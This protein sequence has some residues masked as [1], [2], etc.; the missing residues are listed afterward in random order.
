[1]L[2]GKALG[3]QQA[4]GEERRQDEDL[5][6]STQA[7]HNNFNSIQQDVVADMLVRRAFFF[8]SLGAL[9]ALSGCSGSKPEVVAYPIGQKV[10]VGKQNLKV[11]YFH[12]IL[13]NNN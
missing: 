6:L 7:N 1:V 8:I 13:N 11:T 9:A 5:L 3:E 10:K 12:L 2:G 4:S